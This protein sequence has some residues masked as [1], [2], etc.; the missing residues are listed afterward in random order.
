MD[1]DF[2]TNRMYRVFTYQ[3][4]QI[5]YERVQTRE[6]SAYAHNTGSSVFLLLVQVNLPPR[7]QEL[8]SKYRFSRISKYLE[9][10]TLIFR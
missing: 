4:P 9:L 1:L 8:T 7:A 10:K 2:A 6:M 5:R 3:W